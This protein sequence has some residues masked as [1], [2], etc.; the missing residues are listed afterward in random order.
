MAKDC[1]DS[2][3]V[4]DMNPT[5]IVLI[6]LAA[7]LLSSAPAIADDT[8]EAPAED[9]QCPFVQVSPWQAPFVTLHP[10]CLEYPPQP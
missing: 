10:D 1:P 5:H 3:H 8:E 9:E 4:N 6:A 7:L 2:G